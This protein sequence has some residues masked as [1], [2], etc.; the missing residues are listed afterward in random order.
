[1]RTRGGVQNCRTTDA[2]HTSRSQLNETMDNNAGTNEQHNDI[3]DGSTNSSEQQQYVSMDD[4]NAEESNT[5][6]NIS[7][8]SA[9]DED[10]G[11]NNRDGNETNNNTWSNNGP[12]I[13]IFPFSENAGL[14]IDIPENDNPL[15]YIKLLVSDKLLGGIVQRSNEYTRRVIDSSRPLRRKSVLNKWKEVTLSEM[16]KFYG[17]VFHMGLAGMPPYRAYWSRSRLYKNDMFSSVM[18]RERF[19]SIMRFLHFGDEP[20]QPD[21]CLA[22]VRFLINQLNN[23]MPEIHI[24]H[25]ELSLDESMMLWRS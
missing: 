17:I 7:E 4:G 11:S 3:I 5:D 10:I 13:K 20:Q 15:F 14:K 19:Q 25:K 16:K 21:D 22:K 2:A 18:S 9:V 12:V 24:S 1:M 23:T 6:I 8:K